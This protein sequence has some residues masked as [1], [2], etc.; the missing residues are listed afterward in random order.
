MRSFPERAGRRR[1]G[2]RQVRVFGYLQQVVATLPVI[3]HERAGGL[4]K[5]EA[6]STPHARQRRPGPTAAPCVSACLVNRPV[7]HRNIDSTEVNE[8]FMV[9]PVQDLEPAWRPR[10]PPCGPFYPDATELKCTVREGHP[11]AQ[12]GFVLDAI[13]IPLPPPHHD[14]TCW[15]PVAGNRARWALNTERRRVWIRLLRSRKW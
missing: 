6:G 12:A 3:G 14:R 11:P 7:Q 10:W 8:T 4:R 15:S 13:R 1:R 5:A 9:A 2:S